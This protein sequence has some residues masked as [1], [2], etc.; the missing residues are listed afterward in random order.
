[1]AETKIGKYRVVQELGRG[2]MGRVF[3]GVDPDTSER[4][5][6]K[7]MN[8]PEGTSPSSRRVL[9]ERFRREAEVLKRIDHPNVVKVFAVGETGDGKPY[10]AME[11]LS[12][13]SLRE[14]L[15]LGGPL[16]L[17][18]AE[19][20]VVQVCRALHAAHECGVIHRDV[21]PD[22]V[23]LREGRAEITLADFGVAKSLEDVTLT[24]TGA[25]LG[26]PAYMSPEQVRGWDLDGRSDIFSTGVILYEL[27]TRRRPFHGD[28]MTEVTHRIVTDDP[29]INV[30]LPRYLTDI[31]AKALRKDPDD[32][33][34]SALEMAEHLEAHRSPFAV[35]TTQSRA[36]AVPGESPEPPSAERAGA[37]ALLEDDQVLVELSSRAAESEETGSL[38]QDLLAMVF[39]AVSAGI[40][41]ALLGSVAGAVSAPDAENWKTLVTTM[42]VGI[43]VLCFVVGLIMPRL[44]ATRGYEPDWTGKLLGVVGFSGAL[45]ASAL[46][47]L[48]LS[49]A[50]FGPL[51]GTSAVIGLLGTLIGSAL[52]AV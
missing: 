49:P 15:E 20:I 9:L 34:Q 50:Q 31:I 6:L 35:L 14:E 45:S 8:L 4:V 25:T 24:A 1:M 22:N 33:Y 44:L 13:R 29:M 43:H 11:L 39:S 17:D 51:I 23:I 37:T 52:A 27:A 30:K 18:Q 19:R 7:V 26:T 16:P 12:G 28:G 38:T 10:I 36:T 3:E 47:I 48:G 5:A 40:L 46:C 42:S 21:K 41:G 32:R 2:A